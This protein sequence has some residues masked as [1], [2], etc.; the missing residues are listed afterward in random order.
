MAC[1]FYGG[2]DYQNEWKG[3]GD[4]VELLGLI[5]IHIM[6]DKVST[7]FRGIKTH[8]SVSDYYWQL[9]QSVFLTSSTFDLL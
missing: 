1:W 2:V 3:K 8:K 6:N 9:F 5:L 7:C 4:W